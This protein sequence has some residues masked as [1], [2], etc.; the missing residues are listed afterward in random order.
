MKFINR[1]I[2]LIFG[3]RESVG[4]NLDKFEDSNTRVDASETSRIILENYFSFII[5]IIVII[6]IV[7]RPTFTLDARTSRE[8]SWNVCWRTRRKEEEKEG[9]RRKAKGGVNKE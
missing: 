3:S 1:P 9:K 6:I 7:P 5:I 2:I 8:I 4:K